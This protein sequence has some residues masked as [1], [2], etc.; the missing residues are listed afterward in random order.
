M[1]IIIKGNTEGSKLA[2][3]YKAIAIIIDVLLASTTI[4][5]AMMKGISN[6][7]ISREVE[8]AYTIKKLYNTLLIGERDCLKLPNFDFGNSPVEIS[9]LKKI[10][11]KSAAFTSS[12]GAKRIVEA[13]GS[14]FIIIGSLVN[15]QA[16]ANKVI[17]L[18][19]QK[20]EQ[21]QKVILI[22]A[23]TE[24]SILS[25]KITE[26]QIGA[27]IIVNAFK[28]LGIKIETKYNEELKYLEGLLEKKS[29]SDLFMET[30]HGKKLLG[31]NFKEDIEF[32]GKLN[33]IKIVPISNND[34]MELPNKN[35]AVKFVI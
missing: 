15:A 7:Y 26:D 32:C 24:G 14:K 10:K 17:N 22:P 9:R 5:L 16:V 8:D 20:S 21:K 31:L 2:A 23:Y 3:E 35:L 27:L 34:Y 12:T 30:D 29:L 18:L 4:P 25:A 33:I 13:I 28:Q 1:E 19:Q 6:F 11:T